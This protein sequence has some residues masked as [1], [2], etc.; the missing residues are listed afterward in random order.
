MTLHRKHVEWITARGL[1]PT[2]AE[3]LGLET[4][5]DGGANW[6]A[7][8]YQ[9][10]GETVNHKYRLTS[11]KR[12]KMDV[13]APLAL[14]NADCLKAPEIRN[15]SPLVI[16]EG[17]WDAIAAIQAGYKFVV[18]VP[19]GAPN[20]PTGDID[21]AA[22]Y[23]WIDRHA[24]ALREAKDIVL[25]TDADAPGQ[26][27]RTDLVAV[28]GAGRCRF[29][30][31]PDGCKDLNDVLLARGEEG[32]VECISSSRPFPVKGLYT[33]ADFPEQE[34]LRSYPVGIEPL[35]DSIRIVPGTLTV[36]T[37][38]AN[39]GKSTLMDA[40]VANALQSFPVCV[41]S[42]ET[43]AKPILRDSLRR[44]MLKCNQ[45]SLR[46]RDLSEVDDLLSRRLTI[47]SQS[48]DSE[49]M[50]DLDYFLELAEV[51]VRR[52]RIKMLVIDPWNEMEHHR[53]RHETETD[54]IG[55]AVQR[56]KAFA[57]R[58]DVALWIVA[59]PS[60][61]GEQKRGHYPGLYDVSGSAHWA[62]KAD[63]GLSYHRFNRDTNEVT[64][65][66]TKV[67][68]GYPGRIGEIRAI[69]DFRTSE[70]SRAT[71]YNEEE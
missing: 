32:V 60:K 54:Y 70:F 9:E 51:A 34:E 7:I 29:V 3:R 25:A 31:Y 40:I 61:P 42:F 55:R 39:M 46:S 69:Y 52:H 48:V 1:D 4:V 19:N 43:L 20:K 45:A 59:H 49:L 47:I 53:G 66:V 56:L 37:G 35:A 44:S 71:S 11:E 6:L 33:L 63:Y 16:C 41:A 62:N 2:L 14:W 13:G 27:L 17:E 21:S 50:M 10:D 12:H 15:G 67:R 36:L 28:F 38:Y 23:D 24:E 57:A 26:A 8:P 18:S 5:T 58:N 68:Q 65:A 64:I 22:R 30:E